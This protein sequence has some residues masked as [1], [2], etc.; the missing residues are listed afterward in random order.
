MFI[1]NDAKGECPLTLP[2]PEGVVHL[3]AAKE[4]GEGQYRQFEQTFT[5]SA[6]A[7][8]PVTVVLDETVLL[9]PAGRRREEA[10][11]AEQQRVEQ[12]QREAQ[13]QAEAQQQAAQ[14]AAQAA[15]AQEQARLAAERAA[16]KT[17]VSDFF[18]QVNQAP[19]PTS[20]TLLLYSPVLLPMSTTSDVVSGKAFAL[21][22][23]AAFANPDSLMARV[24]RNLEHPPLA[25]EAQRLAA[26]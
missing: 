11:L 25:S 26:R 14:Q 13:A 24:S 3:R 17:A 18:D 8:K 7:L 1:N 21:N 6:G 16:N 2:V 5:L 19:A 15:A 12:Q 23:P 20:T 4:I 22:D 9:T 10:R